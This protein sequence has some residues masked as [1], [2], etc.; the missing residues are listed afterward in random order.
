MLY[1]KQ[2]STYS[3]TTGGEAGLAAQPDF[4]CCKT[5]DHRMDINLM[6]RYFDGE[7]HAACSCMAE[8]YNSGGDGSDSMPKRHTPELGY[9]KATD[10]R[11][12]GARQD[13]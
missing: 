8:N 12:G 9:R 10:L 13:V 3:T 11:Y 4:I 7:G 6:V 1:S 5:F 2:R